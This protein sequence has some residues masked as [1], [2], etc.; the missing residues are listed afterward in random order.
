MARQYSEWQFFN[1]HVQQGLTEGKYLNAAYTL[2]AA[3]PA[4][5]AAMT[6]NLSV[7]TEVIDP[8]TGEVT[9]TPA[10][11]AS[12]EVTDFLYPIGVIQSF[13]MGQQSNVMRLFEIGSE[14]SYFIRG[15]TVGN[16]GLGRI[17]YHGPSL[18]RV[19]KAVIP[20]TGESIPARYHTA[21][22]VYGDFAIGALM[23]TEVTVEEKLGDSGSTVDVN[24]SKIGTASE[25]SSDTN[26]GI[27]NRYKIPAGDPQ[28]NIWLNLASDLFRYPIGLGLF[29]RDGNND[30]VGAFYFEN[31]HINNHGFATDAG[32][33]ILTENS[34][35]TFERMLPIDLDAVTLINDA[36]IGNLQSETP[37]DPINDLDTGSGA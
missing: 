15:R 25:T 8:I 18:L 7:E 23:G 10:D 12:D 14:R 9:I 20:G 34:S 6:S 11:S 29:L 3:G 36:R 4:R 26:G 27:G 2:I 31:C 24:V 13:N 37:L 21:A 5:L 19:L 28:G 33:T 35:I 32:G 1:K 22:D 16:I 17:M 30:T